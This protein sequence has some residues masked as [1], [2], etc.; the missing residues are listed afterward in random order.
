MI[1]SQIFF[2]TLFLSLLIYWM[3]PAQRWRNI[4]IALISL[5]YIAWYDPFAAILVVILTAFSYLMAWLMEN[6][7]G[8]KLYHRIG[9]TGLLLVLIAF[10]YLGLLTGT[11]NDLVE[12]LGALPVFQIDKILLP[13][14]V[15]YIT[16]KL[17]S[18]ITDVYWGRTDKGK[19]S[20]LLFYSSFFT[21]FVAGPIERFKSF[22][23]QVENRI[24][25]SW[26][27]VE[28]GIQRIAI[29]LF[30]KVVIADWIA[31]LINP[32]WQNQAEFSIWTR[33]LALF[34]FSIQI[35]MDFAGY[36][37]I[38]IGAS[39]MFGIRILENFDWPYLRVN[40]SE[41]WRGWHISLSFWIRDYIF[42][43]LSWKSDNKL[44]MFVAVPL[45]SMGLCGLWHGASWNFFLWGLWHGMGISMLQMWKSYKRKYKKMRIL[46]PTVWASSLS[47]AFTFLFVTVGWALFI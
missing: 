34:G 35:Y 12:F 25:Y 37:D 47:T 3:T 17:I 40:I 29:G 14:G 19:I 22:K 10:K 31:Y 42:F 15:S 6:K 8:K 41:F 30:K 18:Y 21:I 11:L 7:S 32:V 28:T 45:I 46:P 43:P 27:D 23:S 5:A 26:L 16:F 9:V 36:S 20:D 24:T 44:W 4:S 1:I 39:R 2:S 13:L 38:A 33:A